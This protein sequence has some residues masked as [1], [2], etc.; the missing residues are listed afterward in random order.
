M[1]DPFAITDQP[2][3]PERANRAGR[4][5]AIANQASRV[6]RFGNCVFGLVLSQQCDE[7][8][9]AAARIKA[10]CGPEKI[11]AKRI[12]S[13]KALIRISGVFFY[14]HVRVKVTDMLRVPSPTGSGDMPVDVLEVT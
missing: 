2:G 14:D 6:F 7:E 13:W 10:G 11:S 12:A 8:D 3:S 1:Y 9:Q 4:F 5:T